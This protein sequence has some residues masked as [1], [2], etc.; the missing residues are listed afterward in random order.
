M[1]SLK[2]IQFFYI[3]GSGIFIKGRSYVIFTIF[4]FY[5]SSLNNAISQPQE[6]QA[7]KPDP[8]DTSMSETKIRKHPRH[9]NLETE[10][11]FYPFNLVVPNDPVIKNEAMIDYHAYSPNERFLGGVRFFTEAN[12]HYKFDRDMKDLLMYTEAYYGFGCFQLG[13]ELGSI[14]GEEYF[15]VGPQFTV[16]DNVIFKRVSVISRVFPDLVLGYEF[17]SQELK[18]FDGVNLSATGMCR[19]LVPSDEQIIQVSTWVSFEKLH[20]VFFGVEYEYNNAS[21]FNSH[22]YERNHEFFL[23]VKFELK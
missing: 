11:E 6:E 13:A 20:G 14:T 4:L 1:K 8:A 18:L 2:N 19:I 23:G 21:Y 5:L 12:T 7:P 9:K 10:L 15:S 16:Y 3:S 17:T 22:T